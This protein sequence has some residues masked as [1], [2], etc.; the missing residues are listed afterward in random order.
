[1]AII[2][3]QKIRLL[4]YRTAASDVLRSIQKLGV[5]Q[6]TKVEDKEYVSSLKQR[7]KTIF[8]FDY[9]SNRLDF[10]VKFLSRYAKTKKTI[11]QA[12][13]G[14]RVRTTGKNLYK[15][16]NSFYY[17]EII[18]E[19]QNL[20]VKIN[21]AHAK[22]KTL[23]KEEKILSQWTKLDIPLGTS[24]ETAFTET[25]FLSG[26]KD[27]L[28][29]SFFEE[30]SE[31]SLLYNIETVT[32]NN[33]LLTLFKTDRNQIEKIMLEYGITV[34]ALPK[35]R[36]TANEELERIGRARS[37]TLI[38]TKRL[39]E[40]AEELAKKLPELKIVSDFIYWKKQNHN[41]L[42]SSI[43]TQ[44]VFIF[45]GWCPKMEL[46]E[47]K[48]RISNKTPFFSLENI[49]PE[50]GEK[51]PVEIKNSK[52]IKPFEAVTR[53]YGLPGAKDIDPTV[54]LSVFF[55]VFFGF[56]LTDFGYGIVLFLVTFIPLYFLKLPKDIKPLITLLMFG[57]IS[58]TVAGL[59]FGGYFGVDMTLMPGWIQKIQQFDPIKEPVVVLG[60]SLGLG[61]LQ[62]LFG[63][64]LRIVSK[65]KNNDLVGGLLD[66][67]PWICTFV[68]LT[69]FGASKS[70]VI[71]LDSQI[72]LFAV[73]TSLAS[74]ILLTG[75]RESGVFKKVLKGAFNLYNFVGFF[76]DILSYSRLF[77]L[78]LATTAIAFAV[79]MVAF[80]VNDMVPVVGPVL[81]VLVLIVG[82][83]FN[84]AINTLGAFIHSARLQFVEFFG[85]FINESGK[86]F[87]PFKRN[88]RYVIIE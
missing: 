26:E 49:E 30:L 15:I 80:L 7:E 59:F 10:A 24:T 64:I 84:L 82:H 36:G 66:Q 71:A 58:T 76:S 37:K 5:V 51:T 87:K 40:R 1:M 33:F 4:V 50:E 3:M 63:F 68:A 69:V 53:L 11:S 22:I 8:E 77:A 39:E 83:L 74:I 13:D 18:D 45:E 60:L 81:M 9:V 41:L 46:S 23:N 61:V 54:F 38:E 78:G 32:V 55:F 31:K 20:G 70:N 28:I 72:A 19:V 29:Q 6:F 73:Y 47:L 79:N 14:S 88:E 16:A 34:T 25:L 57:G 21:D 56:A 75:H 86:D 52:L 67:A 17:N 2:K 85:K 62:I 65:A 27:A 12:L 44:E 35:R 48:K 43:M 42:S